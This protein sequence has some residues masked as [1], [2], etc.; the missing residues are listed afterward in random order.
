MKLARR[1]SRKV[2]LPTVIV[3]FM[4]CSRGRRFAVLSRNKPF[5]LVMAD[6][7]IVGSSIGAQLVAIIPSATLLPALALL[8]TTSA[9]KIW[10][11]R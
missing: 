2:K 8:L 6:G 7:S 9:I 11:R 10:G 1:L 5:V 4:R 3:G